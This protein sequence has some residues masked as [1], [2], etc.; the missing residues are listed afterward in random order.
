MKYAI[1]LAAGEGTRMRSQINKVMHKVV[2]KPLI[3]HVVDNLIKAEVDEIDVVVGYKQEQ[4]R[5]YLQDKV[6][7]SE[8]LEA[9]GTGDAIKQVQ[10]LKGKPGKTIIVYG[11][12]PLVQAETIDLMFLKA[13]TADCVILTTRLD[14]PGTY[15]RVERDGQGN[16]KAVLQYRNCS[17]DQKLIKEI[18]NGIY[19]IDNELLFKYVDQIDNDNPQGEYHLT[20]I[21]EILVKNG[22]VVKTAR[23]D[24]TEETMGINDRTQLAS[25]TKWLQR[26]INT[27]WMEE[28]V[29]LIDPET[30]YISIDSIIEPDVTIY[31]NVY[32]KGKSVIKSGTIIYPNSW[33]ENST[34]GRNCI[35]DSSKIMDSEIRNNVTVGPFSHLRGHALVEDDARIGNF[36]EFKNTHFKKGSKCA[37]LTYLGD[38]EIGQD[39]NIGCGVVTV[40]YDG[41]NKSKTIVGDKSF[42]GSNAN[43]IA[44]IKIGQEVVVAAGSTISKD[45][46]D[47]DMIIERSQ[48]IIKE[49]R[50]TTYVN[51][52]KNK[53]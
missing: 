47:G 21:V 41:I 20:D 48:P 11:D 33:I 19:C 27:K 40:N 30:V 36:V 29:T 26:K 13:E 44:P 45:V 18:N 9:K 52:K 46:N 15:G 32:I 38:A 31:P 12:I 10:S 50:G 3:G 1:V 39:V 22:H 43:L 23:I 6:S 5:E 35:V 16:V 49:G 34:V 2:D 28:G 37:H 24:E 25:A 51:K 17:D 53:G 4:I 42:I 14:D 8:Q 7:Y